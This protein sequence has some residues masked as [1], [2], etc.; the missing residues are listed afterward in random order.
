[1]GIHKGKF[2]DEVLTRHADYCDWAGVGIIMT[3]VRTCAFFAPFPVLT[4]ANAYPA[5]LSDPS[6]GMK[7]FAQYVLEQRRTSAQQEQERSEAGDG[8]ET[9]R[10]TIRIY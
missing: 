6:D 5:E 8:Q 2:F 10:R 1:M 4:E 3:C 7:S 9:K